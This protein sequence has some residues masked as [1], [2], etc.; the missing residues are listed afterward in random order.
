MAVAHNA[1]SL[2]NVNKTRLVDDCYENWPKYN[3]YFKYNT[4]RHNKKDGGMSMKKI[5]FW[6][7]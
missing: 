5:I 7:I 1:I 2:T 6:R 3:S 4:I